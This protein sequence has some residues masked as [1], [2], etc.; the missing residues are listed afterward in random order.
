MRIRKSCILPVLLMAVGTQA[1]MAQ[2]QNRDTLDTGK[3][4]KIDEVVVTGTRSETDVRHLSQTVSVVGRTKISQAMQ[5]SLLPVLTEQIPGL[6]VTS[7]GV[8]GY[9]VSGGAAGSISL[10]GLSGGAAR[11]MVMIDGH[12]QYAGIFG[13][14]IADA[15]QSFLAERV[16]VLRGPASVLYGSN[17]MAGRG[18]YS[19]ACRLWLV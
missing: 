17:A 7:R 4:Y 11:L 14:P 18:K 8:M 6:F 5:P 10:R 12:P 3:V 15:Y 9:G 16:E 19:S 2:K 13:H 1:G